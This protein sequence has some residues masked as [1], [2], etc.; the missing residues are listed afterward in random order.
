MRNLKGWKTNRKIIVFESDDWGSIRM[1]SK[2]I[3]IKCL[4]DGYPVDRSIYTK[5]DSLESEDDLTFLL[6]LLA[7]KQNQKGQ[8]PVFTVNCL[9]ANP[10]FDK[11]R[12]TDFQEYHYELV[13]ET[14]QRYPKHAR[15]WEIWKKALSEKLFYFQSHGREHLNVHRFLNDLRKNVTEARYAFD[16]GMP[17]IFHLNNIDQ[18]NNY[19]VPFE[20]ENEDDKLSKIQIVEEGL[21]LFEKLFGYKS[22]SFIAGNYVWYDEIENILS[23]NFVRFIQGSYYQLIPKGNYNGFIKVRHI[24]GELNPKNQ[25]YLVRN[26]SFEPST[27]PWKDWVNSC[28]NEINLAFCLKRPAIVSTHRLN[29]VGFIDQ[30]NRD[31]SLKLLD[32]LLNEIINRWPDVEFLNSVE[33]GKLINKTNKNEE[34]ENRNT[35]Q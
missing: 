19:V 34:Y 32:R 26:A 21:I 13:T 33:L 11:I 5:Y 3:F 7:S 9:V 28:L 27:S 10:N 1:P 31:N 29:Y 30:S 18:G 23:K 35:P 12:A 4:R 17:G 8:N 15:N 2:E 25:I 24:T 14:F 22:E 16:L 20:F 6:D